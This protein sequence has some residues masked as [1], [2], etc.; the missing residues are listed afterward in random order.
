[1]VEHEALIEKI[2]ERQTSL[3][4]L[5]CGSYRRGKAAS[6]DIDV[7]I[8]AKAFTSAFP[9][10]GR[11]LLP[12]FIKCLRASGYL[13]ADL[14]DGETKYMGIC[15]LPTH[16]MHRRIDIRCLPFDQFHFG[17]LYFTGS[18]ELNVRM[19]LQALDAGLVLSEYGLVSRDTGPDG[20][21]RVSASS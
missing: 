11:Y 18:R 16:S 5:V 19:R 1:M 21:F 6:G 20:A 8:T 14:A 9:F 13:V 4:L 3:T 15:K 10:G 17:T 2:A 12:N 7:L